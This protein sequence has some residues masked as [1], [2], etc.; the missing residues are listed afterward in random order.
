MAGPPASPP[1]WGPGGWP[2]GYGPVPQPRR[3]SGLALVSLICG[4]GNLVLCVA[5]PLLA[6]LGLVLG[7]LA[8]RER[9]GP[10]HA[11]GRGMAVAGVILNSVGLLVAGLVLFYFATQVY[12]RGG[13]GQPLCQ[14]GQ[15]CAQ[16]GGGAARGR[17]GGGRRD[18]A[19]LG[20]LS[21][22]GDGAAQRGGAP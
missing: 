5:A 10:G 6:P 16:G 1:P 17:P 15:Q 3:S 7:V 20:R 19:P 2:Q 8:L 9:S 14:A 18:P 12:R 21:P 13:P 11:A 4:I 22:D